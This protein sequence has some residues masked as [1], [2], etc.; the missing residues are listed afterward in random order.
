MIL[1]ASAFIRGP[2]IVNRVRAPERKI[3]QLDYSNPSS[4]LVSLGY[5]PWWED[6]LPNLFGI[7]PLEAAVLL[8]VLYYF[9]GSETLYEFAREAGR[10]FSTYAPVVKDVSLDIFY[11]FREYLEE[12]RERASLKKSGVDIDSLPRRTTNIIEKFTETMAVLTDQT[13]GKAEASEL[14]SAY[15]ATIPPPSTTSEDSTILYEPSISAAG[16][17]LSKREVLTSRNID[18]ERIMEVTD[19]V[20]RGDELNSAGLTESIAAVREGLEALGE[21][22]SA[23][24]GM[25]SQPPQLSGFGSDGI[26]AAEESTA[27]Y[28]SGVGALGMS[29]FQ[30]QMSGEWNN[31]VLRKDNWNGE[32]AASTGDRFNDARVDDDWTLPNGFTDEEGL[33]QP[34]GNSF[35]DDND[36]TDSFLQKWER[37]KPP[38]SDVDGFASSTLSNFK[39]NIPEDISA[40]DSGAPERLEFRTPPVS[41]ATIEALKLLDTDY[42]ALRQRLVD[43]LEVTSSTVSVPVEN[44]ELITNSSVQAVVESISSEIANKQQKYW[45]PLARHHR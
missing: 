2:G 10:L 17:R 34:I 14:Q 29:K 40:H 4:I 26:Q 13:S 43:L 1:N 3:F 39:S 28:G 31:R 16:K 41:T 22:A 24:G 37:S 35:D 11:E 27:A 18:V 42:L 8:G 21:K 20:S 38:R 9:Y 15:S 32:A 7:N 30:Q 45:P 19:V 36:F 33:S 12:D 44:N 23:G 5:K 6:D 25:Y